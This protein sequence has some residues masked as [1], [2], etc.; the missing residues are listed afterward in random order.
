MSIT[1]H[2]EELE[3][4]EAEGMYPITPE[5]EEIRKAYIAANA[6]KRAIDT[7]LNALKARARLIYSTLGFED[8]VDETGKKVIGQFDSKSVSVNTSAMKVAHPRLY[9]KY[10]TET[11]KTT[12]YC[13][14]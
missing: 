1:S 11:P 10:V 2:A 7:E 12:F 14:A 3:A 8:F 4:L 13:K 9:K 5:L 6:K